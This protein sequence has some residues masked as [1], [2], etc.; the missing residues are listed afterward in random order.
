MKLNPNEIAWAPEEKPE[1]LIVLG[2][3]ESPP[4]SQDSYLR[5]LA[6]LLSRLVKEASPSEV[7]E[8]N[9]QL[10]LNLPEEEQLWLPADLLADP[11]CPQKLLLNPASLGSR[12]HEFK[13]EVRQAVGSKPMPPEEAF[14]VAEG[15]SLESFLSPLR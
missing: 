11:S 3:Q 6:E 8:A 12:L 9:R 4:K 2:L 7:E 1:L 10:R 5:K 13:Q 14:Q 15:L